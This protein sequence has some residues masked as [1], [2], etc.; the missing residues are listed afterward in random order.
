MKKSRTNAQKLQFL[1]H[2]L[3]VLKTLSQSSETLSLDQFLTLESSTIPI[4]F[5]NQSL[6]ALLFF[7]WTPKIFRQTGRKLISTS[8]VRIQLAMLEVHRYE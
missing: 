3:Y 1:P 7:V 8:C 5:F 6:A 2:F 4:V